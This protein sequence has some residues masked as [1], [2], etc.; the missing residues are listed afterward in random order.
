MN[1]DAEVTAKLEAPG[2]G[3]PKVELLA[4]RVI[5]GWQRARAT[6]ESATA[7]IRAESEAM[8]RLARGCSPE[9]GKQRVLI[10]RLRGMEDSSRY[11]SIYMT[12]EHVR[13]VN[14]AC[15]G[16]IR[17]LTRGQVPER[18]ASTAAVKP[19][20]EV[21]EG[22]LGE[23]EQACDLL[24]K[25]AGGAG[26]IRTQARYAHPWFGPLDAAGWYLMAGFHMRLHRRQMEEILR[27]VK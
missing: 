14:M 10:N 3:L 12:L 27:G 9:E 18:V 15:L 26:D 8:L 5:F 19:S 6:K 21:G 4:A 23:F 24:I 20:P 17:S 2:A 13:I 1:M 25:T 16:A 7:L 11:W 22:V